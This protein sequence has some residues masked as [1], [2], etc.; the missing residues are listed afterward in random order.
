MPSR[1]FRNI[2]RSME[3]SVRQPDYEGKEGRV[4]PVAFAPL[5]SVPLRTISNTWNGIT[6]DG[7]KRA[8]T[9][10]LIRSSADCCNSALLLTDGKLSRIPHSRILGDLTKHND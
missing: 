2:G 5:L 1:L 8:T 6:R 7:D 3:R 9:S 4:W 10:Q